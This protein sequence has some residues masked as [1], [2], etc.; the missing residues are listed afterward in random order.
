[1]VKLRF[2][3]AY[4]AAWKCQLSG[5][6]RDASP[7]LQR[8]LELVEHVG[9]AVELLLRSFSEWRA[10]ARSHSM[11]A[12]SSNS[13]VDLVERQA[14]DDG[15]AMRVERDEPFGFELTERFA[16][17]NAA[18][19]QLVGERVLTKRFS[20]R[21]VA[22]ENSLSQR[23]DRHAGDRLPLDRDHW[24]TE[25][26]VGRGPYRTGLGVSTSVVINTPLS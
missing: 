1:M 6:H 7:A 12:R 8:V 14:R 20:V 25:R 23:L 2:A 10:A 19:A 4:S 15:A 21:I 17:R 11:S 3:G 16:H 24:A 13:S 18:H 5:P 22:A 26:G 9:R